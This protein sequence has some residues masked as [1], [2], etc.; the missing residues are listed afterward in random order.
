MTHGQWSDIEAGKSSTW[1]ELKAVALS[2]QA[3][4]HK[5]S[6]NRI[7]WFS[8]NQNVIRIIQVG[9]RKEELQKEALAIFKLAI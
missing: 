2:L 9:S 5:L 7:R 4:A 6:N 1:R 8:D 3:V